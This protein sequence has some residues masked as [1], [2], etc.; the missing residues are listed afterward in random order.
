MAARQSAQSKEG[1]ILGR[2]LVILATLLVLVLGAAFVGPMF[3]DWNAYRPDIERAASAILGRNVIILGDIDIVVLPEPHFRAKKVVAEGG[4]ADGAQMTAEAVDLSLSLQALSSGRLEASRLKLLNPFLV[5]DLSKPLQSRSQPAEAGALTVAAG[6][7]SLE[8][9]GGRVSVFYEAGQ[10]KALTLS[11]VD[12]TLAAPAPGNAYRF[13]GRV[14][15]NEHRYDVKFLASAASG[16]GVKLTGSALDL[17]SRM[18]FQADGVLSTADFPIFNGAVALNAPQSAALAGAPFEVQLKGGARIDPSGM[19][20]SDLVVTLDLENR[21]QVLTGSANVAFASETADIVLQARSLDADGLLGGGAGLGSP[22]GALA[23]WAAIRSA[24]DRLLWL[25]PDFGLH[26]SLAADQ[27][28][29]HGEL[30]EGAKLRGR[31]SAD[32][33]VFE[34]VQATLPG[35]TAV[36]V[37]G[38]LAKSGGQPELLAHASLEGKNLGRLDRWIAP[39]AANS[40]PARPRSFSV[41][42]ML[43]LSGET[44]ALTGVKGD[45]DGTPFTA[46]LHIDKAP[47]RR[48]QLSLTSDALDLGSLD[49]EQSGSESLS[50]ESVKAAWQAGLGQVAPVLGGDP[51]DFD[52]ADIDVSAGSIRTS[53][54][55]ARNVAVQV[56]FNRDLLTVTKLSAETADGL[57]LQGEG[58]VPLRGA[59]QGR[60]DGRI[61]ARSAQAV[62]K[63]A[64]LAGYDAAN[65]NERRAQDFA[66]AILTINYG[67]GAQDGGGTAQLKGSLGAARL[68]GR[69]QLKGS[70]PEWRAGQL[71][72]V[73]GLSSADGNKLAA[74]LFPG[75]ATTA[76][77]VPGNI[78]IRIDGG[79]G[80]FDTSASIKADALQAQIEGVTEAKTGAFVFTGKAVASS[81]A[82]EDFLPPALL[83]L[84]GGEPK[85]NLRVETSLAI[86]GSHVDAAKLKAESPRNAVTGRLSV[87]M[88]DRLTRIDADLKAD[89][90]SLPAIMSPLLTQLP[91]DRAALATA[92]ATTAQSLDVWSGRPFA[93]SAFHETGARIMLAAKTLKLGD[94][95]ALTD[96][97]LAAKLENDRLEIQTLEGKAIGGDLTASLSLDARGSTVGADA[98]ISLTGADL[99]AL[100]TAG[101]PALITGKASLSLRA[102]GRG[103]SPRGLVA[104]L[105]G[106]G[107]ISLSD[108][109]LAKFSPSGVQKSAEDLVAVQQPL[110]EDAIK[111]KVLEASQ[112]GDFKFHHLKIPVAIRDGMLEIRRASFR[113]RD[114]TVRMEAYLDLANMQAD[115][116]WQAGVSS[117]RRAKWPPVKIQLSGPLRE[118]GGKPRTIA[119]EDF[120]RAILIRKM[121]GDITRLEGLNKP[122]ATAPAPT[123]QTKQEPAPKPRRKRDENNPEAAQASP[124]PAEMTDFEKRMRDALQSKGTA[125]PDAQ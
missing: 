58:V 8:I 24:A 125:R 4:A 16:G 20:L 107:A 101:T 115:S 5:I 47:L 89:Q 121:E 46:S 57:A 106:R 67:T 98:S 64:A 6:M 27:L 60:F 2:L 53:F 109:H 100:P 74:L 113:S 87:S 103:L 38:S 81:P 96:A 99:S 118:L 35:E 80:R 77:A 23:G 43:A 14:A 59:G 3:V 91:Q 90:L 68:E 26:L 75:L 7:T 9:Q 116:T 13:T 30:I 21:A 33:W 63:A 39:P 83:A 45:L 50:A 73:L 79:S 40:K 105:D 25:Y 31:R 17:A 29:L 93:L 51:G 11:E 10:P 54:I 41:N 114:G 71:S 122:Q 85:T 117:D 34:A 111:K 42:G 104:V 22:T 82:P 119:A 76:A 95:F 94:A 66:P 102:S 92:T 112:S 12:G 120:V 72:A 78:A 1:P 52:V 15:Q 88:A 70:L 61:E 37:D 19:A 56:K 124:V 65:V 69:I 48:L 123:W 110:T 32:Q 86:G 97:R 18:A 62:L 55:E 28:E 84:L 44:T 108:G 49:P 36:K